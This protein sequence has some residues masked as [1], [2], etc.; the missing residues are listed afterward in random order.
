MWFMKGTSGKADYLVVA[1]NGDVRLGIKPQLGPVVGFRVRAAPM[2]APGKI[3]RMRF[4]KRLTKQLVQAFKAI[5]FESKNTSRASVSVGV[6]I[7]RGGINLIEGLDATDFVGKALRWL[8]EHVPAQHFTED[9]ERIAQF[10][11]DELCEQVAGFPTPEAVADSGPTVPT[12]PKV[13]ATPFTT[14]GLARKRFFAT[15]KRRA[16]AQA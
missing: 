9:P 11:Y 1:R 12:F 5:P 14:F 2:K 10:L 15:M 6:C 7:N 16:A 3:A 13:Y 8:Q 4:M